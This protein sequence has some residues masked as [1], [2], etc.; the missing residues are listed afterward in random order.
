[1]GNCDGS[2][3]HPQNYEFAVVFATY[4]I[5]YLDRTLP[6]ARRVDFFRRGR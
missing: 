5:Q 2:D 6:F 4:I 1:L 3:I